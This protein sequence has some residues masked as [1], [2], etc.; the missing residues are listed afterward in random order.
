MINQINIEEDLDAKKYYYRWSCSKGCLAR[1]G[2]EHQI[3]NRGD[4]QYIRLKGIKPPFEQLI[5]KDGGR[6]PTMKERKF[7]Q[8]KHFI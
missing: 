5:F 7:N 2:F 8:D 6:S 4:L 3:H 1:K